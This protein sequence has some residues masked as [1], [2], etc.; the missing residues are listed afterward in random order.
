[1]AKSLRPGGLTTLAILNF[2]LGGFQALG[3]LIALSTIDAVVTVNGETIQGG[4]PGQVVATL[5]G[6]AAAGLLITS[7]V[8]FLKVHPISGRLM[9][10][11]YFLVFVAEVLVQAVAVEGV[12]QQSTFNLIGLVYPLLLVVFA[13]IVFRDLWRKRKIGETVRG[14]AAGNTPHTLLIAGNSI[15]QT[16]RG[17]SGV[18]FCVATLV[19][20]LFLA[21]ILFLPVDLFRIQIEAQGLP[22]TDE[23]IVEQLEEISVPILD[24]IIGEEADNGAWARFLLRDRPG[25]LSLVL[26]VLCFFIPV[27]VVFSGFNQIAGD[28]KN[29]G[30]R[31]LL[32]RTTRRDIFFGKFLGTVV[33]AFFLILIL[34]LAVAA[35]FQ[36]NLGVYKSSAVISWT[37]WA[38]LSFFVAALPFIAI[39]VSLSA[40]IDSPFGALSAGFGLVAVFPLVVRG[41]AS[42]WEPLSVI[43]YL[44]PHPLLF[45]FFHPD[46]LRVVISFVGVIAYA[47][48][49]LTGG[50][51]Y[52][53]RRNL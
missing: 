50:Y 18:L 22:V 53:R 51:L 24:T 13:N 26:M 8:G 17:A 4:G 27:V 12:I 21:Q 44:L 33:V 3:G 41:L 34:L 29:K 11:L 39:S 48:V 19:I 49:Y 31:Y 43:G 30:L 42:A 5:L 38:L 16:L 1:M 36:L 7:G 10:N 20:G 47:A 25:F 6:L 2:V 35:Y 32:L 52:F 46:P 15:R 45:S 23:L 28:A 37:L 14:R 40:M 9:A